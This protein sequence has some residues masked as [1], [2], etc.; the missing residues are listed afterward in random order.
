L[1]RIERHP[2]VSPQA[3]RDEVLHALFSARADF[4]ALDTLDLELT[5][6]DRRLNEVIRQSPDLFPIVYQD[7]DTALVR[8]ARDLFQR[9][10]AAR[11]VR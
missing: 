2:Y 8:V 10:E 3:S 6:Q 9:P 4:I 1:R 11:G 7:G 5:G